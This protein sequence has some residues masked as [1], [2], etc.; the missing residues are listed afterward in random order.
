MS[1]VKSSCKYN[2]KN[3]QNLIHSL[4]HF[5]S[6]GNQNVIFEQ[7]P[8]VREPGEH[9]KSTLRHEKTAMS[10]HEMTRQRIANEAAPSP[11]YA[12]AESE[13][14]NSGVKQSMAFGFQSF[15][16]GMSKLTIFAGLMSKCTYL[17][18]CDISAS[19][20][21]AAVASLEVYH[22]TQKLLNVAI[23]LPQSMQA[24]NLKTGLSAHSCKHWENAP[25]PHVPSKALSKPKPT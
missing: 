1:S 16:S 8:V 7:V 19:P 12:D 4:G 15:L 6:S 20:P 14:W 3:L 17:K 13:P 25:W 23:T 21:P 10:S 11:A 2:L 9:C 18:L 22:V 24:K 5:M